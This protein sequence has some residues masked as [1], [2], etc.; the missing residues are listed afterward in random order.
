MHGRSVTKLYR[1][2]IPQ[3][4]CQTLLC[5]PTTLNLRL[6]GAGWGRSPR[7][8]GGGLTR[9]RSRGVGVGS[10]RGVFP[11]PDTRRLEETRCSLAMHDLADVLHSRPDLLNEFHDY[12]EL[13]HMS[14]CRA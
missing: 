3:F 5:A 2:V 8:R 9:P 12:R 7:G 1:T 11:V 6:G 4:Q 10:R 13:N 14:S